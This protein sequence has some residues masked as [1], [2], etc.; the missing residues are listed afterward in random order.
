LILKTN[1]VNV[2]NDANKKPVLTNN[3]VENDSDK[4]IKD[5]NKESDGIEED[6]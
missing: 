1:T 2:K 6:F 5:K 3:Y 4:N